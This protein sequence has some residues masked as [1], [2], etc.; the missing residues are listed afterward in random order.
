MLTKK[1]LAKEFS[2]VVQQEIK[3]HNDSILATNIS[4]EEFKRQ[5]AELSERSDKKLATIHSN[6]VAQAAA[7]SLLKE[8]LEKCLEKCIREVSDTASSNESALKKMGKS[9]DKREEYFLTIE[10]FQL[11]QNKVDEWLANL[12]RSFNVQKDLL[13]QEISKVSEKFQLSVDAVKQHIAKDLN[14][15]IEKRKEINQFLDT[16]SVNFSGIVREMEVCKKRCYIIEKN[17]ENLYTQLERIKE[18][19]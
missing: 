3:N 17:V 14:E 7:M 11:F 2:L 13:M 15:E 6:F 5:I 9:I 18:G 10:G 16:F 4:L 8:S 19:K 1:D 12:R